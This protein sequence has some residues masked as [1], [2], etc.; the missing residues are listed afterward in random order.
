MF[1]RESER[2]GLP[3]WTAEDVTEPAKHR[4]YRATASAH[5]TLDERDERVP[6]SV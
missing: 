6:Q 2:Q 4:L 3:V 1:A 5:W